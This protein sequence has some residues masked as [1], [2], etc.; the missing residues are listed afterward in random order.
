LG[1]GV[2]APVR[3]L[4]LCAWSSNEC[5]DPIPYLSASTLIKKEMEIF[6]ICKEIQMGAVAKSYMRKGFLIYECITASGSRNH[7]LLA[8]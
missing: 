8:A 2:Q 6:L 1:G 4:Q 3:S 5:Y 7:Q